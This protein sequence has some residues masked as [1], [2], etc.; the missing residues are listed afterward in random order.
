VKTLKAQTKLL[1]V[2]AVV[3]VCGLASRPATA[4][5]PR[6]V[7]VVLEVPFAP[8]PVKAADKIN[9]AYEVHLET[10]S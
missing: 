4:Q 10:V 6:P 9:L 8:I 5:A 3:S 2:V 1:F 7:P